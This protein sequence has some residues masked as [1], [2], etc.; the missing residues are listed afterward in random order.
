MGK[1]NTDYLALLILAAQQIQD[2]P[3]IIAF[4]VGASR[5][6]VRADAMTEIAPLTDWTMNTARDSD[7]FPY[8]HRIEVK[9]V[10]YFAITEQPLEVPQPQPAEE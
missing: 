8:Q 5:V 10:T 1:I 7:I 9:G 6:L 2:I 4:D 3:Q